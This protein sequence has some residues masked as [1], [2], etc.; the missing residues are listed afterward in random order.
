MVACQLL[1]EITAFLRE[2]HSSLAAKAEIQRQRNRSVAFSR[3]TRR[4]TQK[5][6]GLSEYRDAV[7][8]GPAER[9]RHAGHVKLAPVMTLS[10]PQTQE[11]D[12]QKVA[13]PVI[14]VDSD[15][16]NGNEETEKATQ[17]KKRFSALFSNSEKKR[18]HLKPE[19]SERK[20]SIS[21]SRLSK[22][23]PTRG[24]EQY[25]FP[26]ILCKHVYCTYPTKYVMRYKL[27][28]HYTM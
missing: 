4:I 12:D 9:L 16:R 3:N 24:T 8:S 21:S 7:T 27:V 13:A 19:N 1:L 26:I 18:K 28:F 14:K 11:G 5:I 25:T 10:V 15:P 6:P 2:S 20:G 23:L 22:K 17:S